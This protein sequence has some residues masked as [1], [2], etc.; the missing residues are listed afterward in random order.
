MSSPSVVE[1]WS[2][3][4][5]TEW[6]WTQ[7]AQFLSEDMIVHSCLK[8][9]VFQRQKNRGSTIWTVHIPYDIHAVRIN[10]MMEGELVRSFIRI[11]NTYYNI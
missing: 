5:W 7:E 6:I 3:I 2:L 4:L 11:I 8:H 9:S 10:Y 1:E